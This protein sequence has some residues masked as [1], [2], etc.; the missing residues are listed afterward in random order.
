VTAHRLIVVAPGGQLETN[1]RD[2]A[3]LCRTI[4]TLASVVPVPSTWTVRPPSRYRRR[5]TMAAS[6]SGTASKASGTTKKAPARSQQSSRSRSSAPPA[7]PPPA[8]A[9]PSNGNGASPGPTGEPRRAFLYRPESSDVAPS[10]HVLQAMILDDLPPIP[11]GSWNEQQKFHFRGI[12]DTLIALNPLLARYGVRIVPHDVLEFHRETRTSGSGKALYG[13]SVTMRFRW[14]GPNG[15]YIDS[16]GIGEGTDSLDKA[17]SKASQVAYKYM[18][19]QALAISTAEA[20]MNETD[21]GPSQETIHPTLAALIE[22]HDALPEDLREKLRLQIHDKIWNGER[23][24]MTGIPEGWWPMYE[25]LVNL[26]EKR[27]AERAAAAQDRDAEAMQDQPNTPPGPEATK[28]D[29]PVS[30]PPVATPPA[31]PAPAPDAQPDPDP[32][33]TPQAP[34]EPE[35]A[36]DAG[37][38]GGPPEGQAPDDGTEDDGGVVTWEQVQAMKPAELTAALE[39]LGA[40]P[41]GKRQ[42]QEQLAAAYWIA[43]GG[44]FEGDEPEDEPGPD[45]PAEFQCP[46]C[47]LFPFKTAE[48][49]DEHIREAHDDGSAEDPDAKDPT[50]AED[51]PMGATIDPETLKVVEGEVGK[52]RGVNARAYATYRKEKQLPAKLSDMTMNQAFELMDFFEKLPS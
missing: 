31:A 14:Y 35:Q 12:D 28:P 4:S 32:E 43:I 46:Q 37:E 42:T 5:R 16:I 1:V 22:R 36:P 7:S 13:V 39:E 34:T 25:S 9:P 44:T 41:G 23:V 29:Q 15:D 47:D 38:P 19:F 40:M 21:R 6:R 18:I 11:K 27:V 10:I 52:L 3:D 45:E 50:P 24:A 33:P 26:G 30:A 8:A 20:A 51:D 2:V 48:E 17:T 49:L